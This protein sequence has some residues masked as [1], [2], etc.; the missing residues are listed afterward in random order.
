MFEHFSFSHYLS[1]VQDQPREDLKPVDTDQNYTLELKPDLVDAEAHWLAFW[2]HELIDRPCCHMTAPK[3]DATAVS[4]PAYMAGAREDFGPV[5]AQALAR[6]ESIYWAGD[7]VP[8][9]SPSFG[10]DMFACWL[11]C[12]LHFPEE[13]TG[14]N[15]AAPCVDDWEESLPIQLDDSNYWWQRTLVFCDALADAFAGKLLVS[16]LDMHS[17]LDVLLA[18]RGGGRL[19]LEL[20]DSPELIDRAMRDVQNLYASVDLAIRKAGRME[21]ACGRIPAYHPVRTNTVQC[22]FA[23]L[24]G[25][26]HFRRWAVPALEQEAA[27]LGHCLMHYDGPEMLVHLDDVCAIP[28]LD[29]IQ[30]Q[31]GVR[32]GPFS[33]WTDLLKRIQNNGVSVYVPCNTESIRMFHRELKPELVFYQ[34]SADH[35]QDADETLN[36]LVVNT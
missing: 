10:P 17:N 11:G 18:M 4:G 7:A 16:H 1:P 22:D 9:Y 14:T 35:Q 31:P 5:I 6:A 36:W 30:W 19:C 25:P 32:N 29:C 2:E 8:A 13:N 34:C 12:D 24:I 26:E 33:R 23:A 3:D 28:G 21:R 20:I 27:H 15:W